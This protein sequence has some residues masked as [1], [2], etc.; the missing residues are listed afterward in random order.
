MPTAK[1]EKAGHFL[2]DQA[3]IL[4]HA[5]EDSLRPRHAVEVGHDGFHPLGFAAG[6]RVEEIGL[7]V[8]HADGVAYQAGADNRTQ[9]AMQHASVLQSA[10]WTEPRAVESAHNA[11][12]WGR[13]RCGSN[14]IHFSSTRESGG[15][16]SDSG[17]RSARCV[18]RLLLLESCWNVTGNVA[19]CL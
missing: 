19:P 6:E 12:P 4:L 8:R 18:R 17:W 5:M 1:L 2:A 10:T 9:P 15:R 7:L 14:W 16:L 11:S 3:A 13:R